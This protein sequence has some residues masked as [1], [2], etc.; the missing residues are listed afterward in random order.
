[1]RYAR[2]MGQRED[3]VRELGFKHLAILRPGI[4]AGNVHTPAVLARLGR[5]N[6]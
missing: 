6:P 5:L 3:T 2:I 1:M 4:I